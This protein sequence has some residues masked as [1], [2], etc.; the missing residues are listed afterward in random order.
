MPSSHNLPKYRKH[1]A[2]GQAVVTLGGKDF[3]LGPHGSKTSIREYDRLIAEYTARGR[4]LQTDDALTIKELLLGYVRHARKH[5]RKHGVATGHFD[6]QKPTIRLFRD[7]YGD[8]LATDFGPLKLKAF[9][10]TLSKP[11]EMRFGDRVEVRTATRRYVNNQ[12]DIIKRIFRWALS[13]EL[14]PADLVTALASVSGLQAGRTDLPEGKP[15]LPVTDDD[16]QAVLPHLTTTVAAMVQV[17]L[18]TGM[19]P[20]EVIQMRPTDVDT[21]GEVWTYT[22]PKHKTEHHGRP[23]VIPIGPKAQ[24]I[25]R[26]FLDRDPTRFCFVPRESVEQAQARKHARR[27][28]PIGQGNRPGSSRAKHR[29]KPPSETTFTNDSYRRSINR[30][31][32]LAGI[33]RWSPNRLR[34]SA[35]TKIRSQFGLEQARVI[36]GHSQTMVTEIYAERDLNQ[37]L[38]VAKIVG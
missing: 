28:T 21:S 24:A 29:S 27:V 23:R 4:V 37:A 36:L 38:E 17:Q 8:L 11:R 9:R 10:L 18:F 19:R 12:V 3:Y 14:V 16:V 31:C 33:A 13:E 30:A 25:L 1:R 15:V 35:A 5:Y 26:P 6:S 34:H 20:N 22:P 7:M 32:D 2:S